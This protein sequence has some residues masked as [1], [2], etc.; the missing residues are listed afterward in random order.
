MCQSD[1]YQFFT[2]PRS[3]QDPGLLKIWH[4]KRYSQLSAGLSVSDL[5]LKN[6]CALT[7]L[8]LLLIMLTIKTLPI[9]LPSTVS[10]DSTNDF[11]KYSDDST[12]DSIES[13]NDCTDY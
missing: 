13:V 6:H 11:T 3:G 9:I 1:H 7:L 2:I 10:T 8:T 12:A 4:I 5:L